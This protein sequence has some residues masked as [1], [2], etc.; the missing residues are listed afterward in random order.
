MR[1][2]RGACV[3]GACTTPSR[4]GICLHACVFPPCSGCIVLPLGDSQHWQVWTQGLFYSFSKLFFQTEE[5]SGP[6]PPACRFYGDRL[7]LCQSQHLGPAGPVQTQPWEA[8]SAWGQQPR[9]AGPVQTHPANTL[10][11]N[12]LQVPF[13]EGT[14]FYLAIYIL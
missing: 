7:K 8:V 9:P 4:I 14:V 5:F 3:H 11:A 1:T 10:A 2:C 12:S 6:A 13:H